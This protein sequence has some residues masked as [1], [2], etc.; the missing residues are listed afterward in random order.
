MDRSSRRQPVWVTGLGFV[1]WALFLVLPVQHA[2]DETPLDEDAVD[3]VEAADEAEAVGAESETVP[4]QLDVVE[5][6]AV[7]LDGRLSND[8]EPTGYSWKIL[9]GEGGT[10][11]SADQQ[12]AVFLAPKVERGVLQFVVELTVLYK[13]QEPSVRQIKIRVLP[14]DAAKAAEGEDDLSWI[15]DFYSRSSKN[16][17][18]SSSAGTSSSGAK[19]S[20]SIGVSGGSYGRRVGFGVRVPMGYPLTQPVDIPPPGQTRSYGEGTWNPATPVPREQLA[21][22]FPTEAIEHYEFEETSARPDAEDTED[23]EDTNEADGK[24][25]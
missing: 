2:S 17:E 13:E 1:A 6:T 5:L 3:T 11:F 22:T 16:Q 10:L 18:S 15:D 12:D 4:G 14:T 19:P 25:G 23:A 24:D 20:V 8:A 7:A 9:E 21:L